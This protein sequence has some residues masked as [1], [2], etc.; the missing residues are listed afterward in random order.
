MTRSPTASYGLGTVTGVGKGIA[1]LI[2][3][4]SHVQQIMTHPPS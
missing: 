4:G 2:E 1:L 3:F